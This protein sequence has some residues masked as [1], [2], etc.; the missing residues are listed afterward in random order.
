MSLRRVRERRVQ[1]RETIAQE[2]WVGAMHEEERI[3]RR[4]AGGCGLSAGLST[5]LYPL[6]SMVL[7]SM[8]CGVWWYQGDGAMRC[9][10]G[11]TQV[12]ARKE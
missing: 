11:M 5:I 1:M 2:V 6:S 8:V 12:V 10:E 4:Q 3:E 7:C 9:Q